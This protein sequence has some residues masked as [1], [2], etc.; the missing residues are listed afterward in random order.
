MC[1]VCAMDRTSDDLRHLYDPFGEGQAE[2]RAYIS[3]ETALAVARSE[4][5]LERSRE[6]L[7]RFRRRAEAD[8]EAR[9][10]VIR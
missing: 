1:D 7:G 8:A 9:W 5:T 4:A 6:V 3:R 10:P 2:T